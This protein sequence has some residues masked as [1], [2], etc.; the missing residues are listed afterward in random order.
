MTRNRG[1]ESAPITNECHHC[2]QLILGAT[3]DDWISHFSNDCP[4]H[5]QLFLP[6]I[7]QLSPHT[8]RRDADRGGVS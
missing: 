1:K 6:F 3:R 5:Q 7:D 2:G 8:E 4:V